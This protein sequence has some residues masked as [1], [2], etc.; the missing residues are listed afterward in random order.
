MKVWRFQE[1][2]GIHPHLLRG[3][4]SLLRHRGSCYHLLHYS[5]IVHLKLIVPVAQSLKLF[6][7][8]KQLQIGLCKLLTQAVVLVLE[9]LAL[10]DEL[11]EL[12]LFF[13]AALLRTLFVLIKSIWIS[14]IHEY[15]LP[16]LPLLSCLIRVLLDRN[17][18]IESLCFR[19]LE[20][21][22]VTAGIVF[23]LLKFLGGLKLIA[24][25]LF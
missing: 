9:G 18:S 25:K 19:L 23:Y 21:F 16:L 10:K 8:V 11:L 15:Y 24:F 4:R 14:V 20:L 6:I 7:A 1:W 17:S 13:K 3:N 5:W 2:A 12:K 22:L